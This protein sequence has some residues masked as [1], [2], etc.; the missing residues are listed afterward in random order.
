MALQ[1]NISKRAAKSRGC[2][3]ISRR[4]IRPSAEVCLKCHEQDACTPGATWRISVHAHNGVT[5]NDCHRG[6]YNVQPG[7]PPTTTPGGD[8]QAAVDVSFDSFASVAPEKST[9]GTTRLT[10]LSV[11][12]DA[13]A[14]ADTR[15]SLR[16]TSHFMGAVTPDVCYRCHQ[17]KHELQAVAS[18]HQIG[19]PNGFNCNTCHDPHGKILESSRKDLCLKCHTGS[20]SAA[21][22]SSSHNRAGVGCTDCHNPHPSSKLHTIAD[23]NHTNIRRP[24]R[25]PMAVMEPDACYKCHAKI[26][27]MAGM[28][29]HHPIKEGK[30]VCSDC[31]DPHGQALDNLKEPTVNMVC[32]RCHMEKQG[33]F[34]WEHPPVTENCTICHNPHGTVANNLLHQPTTFLCLRCHTGHRVAPNFGPH[35]GA[36]LVDVGTSVKSQRAFYS[37]CTQCHSQIHGSDKPTPHL[38]NAFLR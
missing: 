24:A 16:G 4:C 11:Q 13:A 17:E 20:P 18:P 23:I 36:G 22:H 27:A 33:P 34:V 7:T 35:T 26:M 29:S 6:H 37:D 32:Y 30:M 14:A 10:A 31:H 28:P 9:A 19:G 1:A 15:P 2:C 5:C 38:P 12:E 25:M 3:S 8:T 21:W